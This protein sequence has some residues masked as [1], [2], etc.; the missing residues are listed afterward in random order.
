VLTR[1][2]AGVAAPFETMAGRPDSKSA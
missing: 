2:L 1:H